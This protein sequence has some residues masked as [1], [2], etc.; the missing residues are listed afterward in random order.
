MESELS[1]DAWLLAVLCIKQGDEENKVHVVDT[2]EVFDS[3]KFSKRFEARRDVLNR[4]KDK[5]LIELYGEQTKYNITA[6]GMEY[7]ANDSQIQEFIR[8]LK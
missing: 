1:I 4:L 5:G 3:F 6:K 8:S 2:Y 7:A